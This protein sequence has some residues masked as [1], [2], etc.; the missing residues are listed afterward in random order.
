[1]EKKEDFKIIKLRQAISAVIF[2]KDKFLMMSG[3]DWPEGSWAFPQGGIEF[4]ETH[5]QAVER[6][7]QEELGTSNFKILGKSIIE[8]TYLFPEKIKEK[9]GCEGQYQ[10]IWFVEF[11]GEENEII[12]DKDELMECSW[13]D[14]EEILSNMRFPEQ[15][16]TFKKVLE[17]LN[18]LRVSKIF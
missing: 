8:H 6:E 1:M 3:T 17:E 16:D 11:K 10:T 14:Q 5:I 13:F 7:L 4:G 2:K 9:R 15:I 12:P 18:K